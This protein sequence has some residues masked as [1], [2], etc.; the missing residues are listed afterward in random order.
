MVQDIIGSAPDSMAA[1]D[2]GDLGLARAS[3]DMGWYDSPR[4]CCP[5]GHVRRRTVVQAFPPKVVSDAYRF[6]PKCVYMW[7][8][9]QRHHTYC[10]ETH[11]VMLYKYNILFLT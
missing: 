8:R 1:R 5:F 2:R 6:S 3:M 9:L 4:T 10:T 7:D 11:Y